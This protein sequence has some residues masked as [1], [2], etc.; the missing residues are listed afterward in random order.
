MVLTVLA[1]QLHWA[2]VWTDEG[3]ARVGWYEARLTA[4]LDPIDR[5]QS[6][7]VNAPGPRL[8]CGLLTHRRFFSLRRVGDDVELSVVTRRG[9]VRR[10]KMA[11]LE[12]AFDWLRRRKALL[13][14]SDDVAQRVLADWS[15]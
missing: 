10:L 3:D 1:F 5:A 2:S 13:I 6:R 12:S 4:E 7:L 11:D 14:E 8:I 9:R 15:S